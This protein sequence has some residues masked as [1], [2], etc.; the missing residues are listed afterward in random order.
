MTGRWSGQ[1]LETP[2]LLPIIGTVAER[3]F[4]ATG[5]GGNGM[6]FGT[7]AA[8]MARTALPASPIPGTSFSARTSDAEAADLAFDEED[9]Q[10]TL[11][12]AR[13]VPTA[14]PSLDPSPVPC[15]DL[16]FP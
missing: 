1:V 15:S 13:A 3:Q 9:T 2:D 7:L 16:A 10:E 5:F 14:S 6:T 12:R 4:V 11:R 8:M